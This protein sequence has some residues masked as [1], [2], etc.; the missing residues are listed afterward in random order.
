MGTSIGSM[1]TSKLALTASRYAHSAGR[2]RIHPVDLV[3]AIL[4]SEHFY[5]PDKPNF[6]RWAS[7]IRNR[8]DASDTIKTPYP[9]KASGFPSLYELET[10]RGLDD[11]LSDMEVLLLALVASG[12]RSINSDLFYESSSKMNHLLP[13]LNSWLAHLCRLVDHHNDCSFIVKEGG[14]IVKFLERAGALELMR[15]RMLG[16]DSSSFQDLGLLLSLAENCPSRKSMKRVRVGLVDSIFMGV[17]FSQ[18]LEVGMREFNT[19]MSVLER[20]PTKKIAGI[21]RDLLTR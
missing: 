2:R 1:I 15:V 21:L 9:L 11:Q 20:Q 13:D 6:A 18:A 12:D 16:S 7:M 17:R 3:V 14:L 8:F 4:Q 10:I 19:D 5:Q